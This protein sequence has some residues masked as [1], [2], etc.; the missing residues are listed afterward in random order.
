[1]YTFSCLLCD[2]SQEELSAHML[3]NAAWFDL[4]P[5]VVTLFKLVSIYSLYTRMAQWNLILLCSN[6]IMKDMGFQTL[7]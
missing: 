6:F 7:Y 1:M 3:S 5:Y 2:E 4:I